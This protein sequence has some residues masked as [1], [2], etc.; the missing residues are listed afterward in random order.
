MPNQKNLFT[1]LTF[2]GILLSYLNTL[3]PLIKIGNLEGFN[4]GFWFQ[5]VE[6]TILFAITVIGRYNANSTVYTPKG[7]PGRNA[8]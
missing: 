4:F 6:T 5:I 8:K 7:F 3:L 2:W 1:S